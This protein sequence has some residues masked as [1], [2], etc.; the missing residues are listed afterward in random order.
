MK[1][2]SLLLS[3]E[4]LSVKLADLLKSSVSRSCHVMNFYGP[5]ETTIGSVYHE[6]DHELNM[7]NIPI[8]RPLPNYCCLI[9]DEFSESVVVD[10][11]GELLLGG[12]GVFAGYL[13]RDDL[14]EKALMEINGEL[15]YRTG[16]L[17]KMDN[18]GLLHYRGRKDHQIKLHGQ[19]IELGEIEQCLLNTTSISACVVMKWGDDHLIA[20]VQSSNIDENHLREHCQLHLPPHMI[21]SFFIILDKLPLNANGKVDRK[22]LPPP[23]FAHLS[24]K[25]LTNGTQVLSP[26][27][28]IEVT[29]H[30]IWCDIFYQTG[31]SINT[32]IF[33]IGGHSLLVM[34]L[35]QI[36]KKTFH[37]ERNAFSVVDLFQHPTIMDHAQFIHQASDAPE[38]M[39]DRWSSL[40]LIQGKEKKN[41][42]II[43]D[44]NDYLFLARASFAQERILLDEQIRFSSVDHNNI[45][46][47]S[48]LYRIS[49]STNHLTITR[50]HHAFQAVIIKHSILRTA[51]YLDT[52]GIII[53]HCLDARV[54]IG[55]MRLYSFS[56]LNFRDND[57]GATINEIL[58][59]SDLF[60]LSKGRVIC[61]HI[62]RQY[63]SNNDDLLTSDD[64]ILINIHHSVFDGVSTSIFLRDLCL[65]YNNDCLLPIDDN[66]LQ[67]VD[68][69]VHERLMDMT[70]SRE[71]W[72]SH[73]DG[74]NL[75][76]HVS[77][78]VDR[79]RSP[80]D[81]RSG[82]PAVA[83]ISFDKNISISFLNYA[84]T[85]QVT[86]FQLGLAT[87]YAFLFKLDHGQTD[88][89][90]ASVN[91]N[92]Y[93][94]EIQNLIGMFV[95]TIPYRLQID[96]HWSF[97]ELVRHVREQCLSILEYSHYPLQNIL[98]DFH[99]NQSNA[100]F[101]QTMFDFTTLSS[102]MN[103]LSL[104]GT[105]L[106]EVSMAQSS[107][108]AKFDFS[109]SFVYNRA[110]DD[111]ILSCSFICSGD[112]FEETSVTLIARRFQYVF[113]QLFSINSCAKE[114]NGPIVSINKVSLILP[115]EA[116]EIKTVVFFTFQ[117]AVNEG[118]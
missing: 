74:Y 87:F 71:F 91:A 10:Q 28:E 80:G 16:D 70:S 109:M 114:M 38:T 111:D 29:I 116:D 2:M 46:V 66:T 53:Q 23:D 95:S 47:V 63:H 3:G 34:Q 42:P 39:N 32:N 112:L 13:R 104:N 115:E 21:P 58:N 22:L 103:A 67:Y 88:L 7:T 59:N 77:W 19:R 30:Q 108:V 98:A 48:L 118:M 27:N 110:P 56:V 117:N 15:F 1:Y 90:I 96:S 60:D 79:Y 6:V 76:H 62:L 26:R 57:I 68:Y 49:P 89:C 107:E 50:L 102:N 64:M 41:F 14:T 8:G 20:Y 25:H 36:Y 55:D 54:V 78:P 97:D 75:N 31:I 18:N 93:R 61:C 9:L 85:H 100:S 45:Y 5:A 99:L 17:I 37:L 105:S 69:S 65:A 101:L 12:V 11:Q 106:E 35:S 4:P 73:L 44:Y 83:E 86:P 72:R 40:H 82:L 94:S 24:S 84:S 113:K 92:R 33:T 52:N 43:L 81:R 51:L